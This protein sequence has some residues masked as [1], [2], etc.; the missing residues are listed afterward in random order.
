M[1]SL[2]NKSRN[3]FTFPSSIIVHITPLSAGHA[4]SPRC[5]SPVR[6]ALSFFDGIVWDCNLFYKQSEEERVNFLA[7]EMFHSYRRHF[8]N[9]SN[10][11]L[12]NVIYTWQNEGIADLIDKKDIS[13][14]SS[15]FVRYG[16]P[17]SYVD[18]YNAIYKSTPQLIKELERVTLS[19]IGNEIT[20][21]EFNAK[22]S[23][24]IQFG[25]HPNAYY[26]TT[27]IK[28]SG[29]EEELINTFT[30][31]VD[32]MKLYNKSIE[33]EYALSSEFM[34]YIESLFSEMIN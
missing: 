28:N 23:D 10:S 4:W 12:I 33:E 3:F 25:G 30:S 31:P 16:L 29:F 18:S 22:L 6:D 11:Y 26:M 32:F 1:S 13:E 19:F 14:L 24:F 15:V 21:K 8:V 7:H 20:E 34:N 2:Y 5:G 17:E 9:D 27:L